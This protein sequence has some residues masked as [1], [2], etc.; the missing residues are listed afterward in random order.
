[1]TKIIKL[2]IGVGAEEAVVNPSPI[3]ILLLA[4]CLGFI[5]LAIV[6][7]FIIITGFLL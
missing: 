5:F 4:I 3:K 1:L 7:L 2:L 6:T